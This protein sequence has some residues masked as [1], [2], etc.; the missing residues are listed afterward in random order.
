[1]RK[2][3][4][5]YDREDGLETVLEVPV[6]EEMF[7][8]MGSNSASRWHNMRALMKAETAADKFSHLL[9]KSNSEFLALL[10]IV[11]APLIPFHIQPINP[12]TNPLDNHSSIFTNA[13][14]VE[15]QVYSETIHGSVRWIDG[16]NSDAQHVRSWA[17]EN[18][19]VRNAS[20]DGGSCCG[21]LGSRRVRCL[22]KES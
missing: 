15:G 7:A 8:S 18:D 19:W 3:C 9:A 5:N 2:L 13:G 20:G 4:P 10:K 11:G 16:I 21:K 6:P 17:S 14:S 12:F 1:M 22:A